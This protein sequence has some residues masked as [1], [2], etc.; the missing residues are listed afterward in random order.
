MSSARGGVSYRVRLSIGGGTNADGTTAPTP[1]PGMSATARLQV[2]E[3]RQ[4]ITVPAAA[5]FSADGHDAVWVVRDGRAQRA[6]VTVG[7]QGDDKVQVLSG[8]DEGQQVVAGGTDKV[9]PG[10]PVQ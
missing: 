4:A 10:Q 6:A 9:R 5:V 1:R 3:A 2:R 7:V 8:V